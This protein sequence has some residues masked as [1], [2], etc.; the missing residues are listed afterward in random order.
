MTDD[1]LK[2]FV[3]DAVGQMGGQPPASAVDDAEVERLAAGH[4]WRQPTAA[5]E[6]ASEPEDDVAEAD[7]FAPPTEP[8]PTDALEASRAVD[9]WV[10][11]LS[12]DERE[13]IREDPDSA[14][15][16]F[17][18]WLGDRVSPATAE[19][20]FNAARWS[21]GTPAAPFDD[22]DL[23]VGREAVESWMASLDAETEAAVQSDPDLAEDT[24]RAWLGS[25]TDEATAARLF[26]VWASGAFNDDA[27]EP[28]ARTFGDLLDAGKPLPARELTASILAAPEQHGYESLE[29]AE[30][31]LIFSATA[32]NEEFAAAC[33]A[34]GIDPE[35]AVRPGRGDL[36][37]HIEKQIVERN[38]RKRAKETDTTGRKV[39]L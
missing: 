19:A 36:P 31:A 6:P 39:Y 2:N 1:R 13:A 3:A 20:V 18:A 15:A 14:D 37:W 26:D 24:Y 21:A 38:L 8:T 23:V 35:T 30:G 11:T 12:A 34:H 33:R 16:P 10:E 22:A 5:E 29:Q 9:A 32:T 28:D 4:G 17:R 25:Q 7:D 27:D